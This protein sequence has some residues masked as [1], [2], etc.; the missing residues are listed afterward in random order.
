MVMYVVVEVKMKMVIVTADGK[1]E[2]YNKNEADC[3][4]AAYGVSC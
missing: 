3:V 2:V 1:N 4:D